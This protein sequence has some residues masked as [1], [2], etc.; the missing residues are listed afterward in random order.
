[1]KPYINL[2]MMVG[3]EMIEHRKRLVQ[4]RFNISNFYQYEAEVC[5]N[6][7]PFPTYLPCDL[8]SLYKGDVDNTVKSIRK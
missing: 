3:R 2:G 5:E 4:E 1:M 7:V 6:N 8:L